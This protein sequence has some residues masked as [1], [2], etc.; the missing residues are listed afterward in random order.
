MSVEEG[1][2]IIYHKENEHTHI[3]SM[4]TETRSTLYNLI[5][6]A[7]YIIQSAFSAQ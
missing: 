5:M 7:L 2:A 4:F 1:Q 3:R 6:E